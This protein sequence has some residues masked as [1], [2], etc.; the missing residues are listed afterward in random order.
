MQL[1][2]FTMKQ[3]GVV[4]S[5]YG[6]K[7]GVPR[8][9]NLADAARAEVELF[10]PWG[11]QE[12]VRDLEGISHIW[13]FFKF[14]LNERKEWSPTIRPPRMGGNK[15]ISVFASRSPV[16]PNPV[17]L[18]VVRYYGC[19]HIKG[20]RT[21]LEVGGVDLVDGTPIYD[22]KPYVTE[23]DC[24]EGAQQGWIATEDF[25]PILEVIFTPSCAEF[26]ASQRQKRPH[27]QALIEQVIGLDPRPA[28]RDKNGEWGVSLYGCN[29]RWRIVDDRAEV[30][31]CRPE[32]GERSAA[33]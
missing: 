8:T 17:G 7:F 16:R 28:Y 4:H 23:S 6:E 24:I 1:Q 25:K 5:C 18:S 13:L 2:D 30:Y 20:G 12:A 33:R 14:H 27:L 19:R 15:R 29:V 32:R 11:V 26:L 22:I 3:I 31:E 10:H 21:F 9:S